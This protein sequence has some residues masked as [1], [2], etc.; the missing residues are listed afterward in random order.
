MFRLAGLIYRLLYNFNIMSVPY[1]MSVIMKRIRT[2]AVE[3][4]QWWYWCNSF[5]FL[6]VLRGIGFMCMPIYN[7]VFMLLDVQF[8]I[9]KPCRIKTRTKNAFSLYSKYYIL[10][11]AAKLCVFTEAFN[12]HSQHLALL[13]RPMIVVHDSYALWIMKTWKSKRENIGYFPPFGWPMKIAYVAVTI[14]SIIVA[15]KIGY[16]RILQCKHQQ[17]SNQLK[18]SYST[19]TATSDMRS[20][21][22][23]ANSDTI[24][25][26]NSA[27][28][29]IWRHKR[30][31]VQSTYTKLDPSLRPNI[32]TATGCYWRLEF[33]MV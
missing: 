29:I 18:T 16:D 8:H 33:G 27:N 30:N 2:Y 21:V 32:S 24:V 14:F 3:A 10:P 17:K 6:Y 31:F 5:I 26:D 7:R 9:Q 22:F 15:I 13:R 23:D 11:L 1:V 19:S 28:C 12:V 4:L 20:E 25:V